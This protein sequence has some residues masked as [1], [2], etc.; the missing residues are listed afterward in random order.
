MKPWARCVRGFFCV[1]KGGTVPLK[2]AFEAMKF[3]EVWTKQALDA[4]YEDG[5]IDEVLYRVKGGKEATVYCCKANP[6]T[7]YDLVAAK[8]YRHRETRSMK[9]YAAYQEGRFLTTDKRTLRAIKN[10]SRKGKAAVDSAW[11]RSEYTFMR[12]FYDAGADVPEPIDHGPHSMLMG[13]VGDATTAAPTLHEVRL[14]RAQARPLFEQILENVAT[15]L[16]YDLVHGDLSAFN[17]LYWEGR[18]QRDRL[19]TGCESDG[20]HECLPILDA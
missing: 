15:F 9:N 13:Y 16:A 18:D 12:T 8:I 19:P 11:I 2:F 5:W 7:G 10:K 14:D 17:I 3:E 6:A 4:F 20:K 1:R